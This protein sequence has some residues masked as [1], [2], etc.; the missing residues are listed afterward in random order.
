MTTAALRKAAWKNEEEQISP[1]DS[2]LILPQI[3]VVRSSHPP[4][5]HSLSEKCLASH[6]SSALASY[7]PHLEE[8]LSFRYHSPD[9]H[10][11]NSVNLF[12]FFFFK[13]P[14]LH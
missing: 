6:C 13:A 7:E 14:H 9:S 12:F 5:T 11:L 3:S 8:L 1:R 10:E 4:R 2:S